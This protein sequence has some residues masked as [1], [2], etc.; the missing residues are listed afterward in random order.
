MALAVAAPVAFDAVMRVR[1]SAGT[2]PVDFYGH[3]YMSNTTDIEV[4]AFDTN[5][6]I[7][8]DVKHDD[9]LTDGDL[10]YVQAAILYTSLGGQRRLRIHNISFNVTAS[11]QEMFRAAE[12]DTFVNFLSKHSLR[13]AL[14][15]T[16]KDVRE[17]VASQCANTLT[18][19]RKNCAQNSNVGQLILPE[20]MKLL[21]LYCNCVLKNDALQ[22]GKGA[23]SDE[24]DLHHFD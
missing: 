22:G 3:M 1:T 2:R 21:P 24:E 15:K 13:M 7:S 16:P 12:L 6:A 23:L 4:A 11:L 10:V 8:V 20:G 17:S 5:K 9:K 19:Y 18:C 14:N